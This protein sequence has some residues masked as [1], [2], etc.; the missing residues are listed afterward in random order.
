M[1]MQH[2]ELP[3]VN[4]ETG[5]Q[6]NH[7]AGNATAIIAGRSWAAWREP[8][9]GLCNV[10]HRGKGVCPCHCSSSSHN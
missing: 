7:H 9:V 10:P 4:S 3:V 8:D 6:L 2:A 5:H 1:G